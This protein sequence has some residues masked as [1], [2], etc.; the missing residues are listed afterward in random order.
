MS[1]SPAWKMCDPP[2]R[3]PSLRF[4]NGML[5]VRY[6]HTT[7]HIGL[8]LSKLTA[9]VLTQR[10]ANCHVRCSTGQRD[11]SPRC[12]TLMRPS[13]AP[14]A[15]RFAVIVKAA[16]PNCRYGCWCRLRH[17]TQWRAAAGC[18]CA[19]PPAFATRLFSF[20][21]ARQGVTHVSTYYATNTTGGWCDTFR[22][23]GRDRAGIESSGPRW[24]R[25]W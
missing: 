21:S 23:R 1:R 2:I 22:R 5:M 8:R 17:G 9:D 19:S 14:Q 10:S 16:Q 13:V 7:A 12:L 4:P 25:V 11:V 18:S 6:G 20:T 15:P 3:T 24:N